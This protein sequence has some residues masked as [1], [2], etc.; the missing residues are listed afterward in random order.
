MLVSEEARM[1]YRQEQ[2]DKVQR[3]IDGLKNL[4]FVFR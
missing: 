1:K 3:S 2:E 4:D